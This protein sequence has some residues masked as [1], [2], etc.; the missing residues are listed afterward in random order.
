MEPSGR[1]RVTRR[2]VRHYQE[3]I[4]ISN[5]AS[6]PGIREKHPYFQER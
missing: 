4:G 6:E 2:D 1:K 3:K 5:V